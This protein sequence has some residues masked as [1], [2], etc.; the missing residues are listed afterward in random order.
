MC[1]GLGFEVQASGLGVYSLGVRLE[2]EGVRYR[3]Q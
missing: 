1:K 2:F 3:A